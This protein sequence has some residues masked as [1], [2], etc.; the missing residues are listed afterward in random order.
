M[1]AN[2]NKLNVPAGTRFGHL[3]VVRETEGDVT[4]GGSFKRVF[5]L[6]CE[7]G[8]PVTRRLGDLRSRAKKGWAQ[9]CGCIG[10]ERPIHA[11]DRFGHLTVIAET[12]FKHYPGGTKER[13]FKVRCVCGSEVTRPMHV[14]RA[15]TKNPVNCGCK[16]PSTPTRV[17]AGT[18]Y[19]QL[20]VLWEVDGLAASYGTVR[21]FEVRCS[22][23]AEVVR[24]LPSLKRG[25]ADLTCGECA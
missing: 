18:M 21:Q 12:E 8:E 6:K 11:G 15:R 9:N 23:G 13:M 17:P 25:R 22:C 16:N 10:P 2:K 4:R 5:L 19:G 20:K 24:T 3:T 1:A 14:F 7:C